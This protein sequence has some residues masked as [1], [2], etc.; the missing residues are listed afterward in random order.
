LF[1]CRSID[2]VRFGVLKLAVDAKVPLSA[3]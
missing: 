1:F 2:H 3:R